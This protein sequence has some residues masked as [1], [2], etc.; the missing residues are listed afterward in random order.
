MPSGTHLHIENT[1]VR[2]PTSNK[3]LLCRGW[4]RCDT[5]GIE[6]KQTFV[7]HLWQFDGLLAGHRQ[8]PIVIDLRTVERLPLPH[9]QVSRHIKP[10]MVRA[11]HPMIRHHRSVEVLWNDAL[12]PDQ[13]G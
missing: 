2:M 3:Q 4:L 11:L 13:H 6:M 8:I 7:A 12:A 5:A 10:E 1:K 9:H